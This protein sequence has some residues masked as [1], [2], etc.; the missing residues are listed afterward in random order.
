LAYLVRLAETRGLPKVIIVNNRQVFIGKA[1]DE[2]TYPKGVKLN[3]IRPGKR[4]ENAHVESFNGQLWDE[5][6]NTNDL[7][8]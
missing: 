5:C 7:L 3:F 4:I 2:W 6:L 1:L 8:V